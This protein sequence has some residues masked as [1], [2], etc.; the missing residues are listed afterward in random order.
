MTAFSR[1]NVAVLIEIRS[2]SS[3][4]IDPRTATIAA[5]QQYQALPP[6]NILV[7][8]NGT[9]VPLL[10]VWIGI[11]LAIAVGLAAFV[12]S[13]GS[14]QEALNEIR[15][16]LRR[17]G[18]ALGV[19]ALGVVGAMAFSMLDFSVLHG[20]GEWYE[21]GFNDFWRSWSSSAHMTYAGGYGHIYNLDNALET[22]PGWL[23][24]IAPISRLAFGLSF[25]YPSAVLYPS[26]FWVAGPLFLCA[27]ALPMCAGD[28][29]MQYLGVKDVRRR[30]LV[31][32]T[33]AITLPPI[34]LFGHSE[35]LLA[36][37]AMLYGLIAAL[38]GRGRATGWWLG[39]ALAFQFFAFLAVPI[40]LVLLKRRQWVGALVPMVAVPLSL[41]IV[42]LAAAPMSTLRQLIHQ[43]VFYDLGYISPTWS[44]D[45]GVGA[46]IRAL[47][48]LS[49]IPAA[50]VLA[51]I[52]PKHSGARAE[53][54][55][56]TLALLF[57]L[58]VCEPEL[59]P[60]FL[61][62]SLALFPLCASK[63]RWSRLV[64]ASVLA[65]WLNWW[66]HD[67]VDA[68]WLLW[69]FLV[70]Q[71]AALSWLAFPRVAVA[72]AAPKRPLSGQ[73]SS[74]TARPGPRNA[75]TRKVPSP[76]RTT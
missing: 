26:A 29:W 73:R 47:V 2:K 25:P 4:G 17:R 20:V 44:L 23:I 9:D 27:M 6:G 30:L 35:D 1:G 65:V 5:Q 48:A 41:L 31:L 43:Q 10:V 45:P 14:A 64:A 49:A 76:S 57:T 33:M 52:L 18:L 38:E 75:A 28:R 40:A 58:R 32:G 53:I 62:P 39:V 67:A 66:L 59:V 74:G 37:G 21:A 63:A 8:T 7:S 51:R 42:P 69:F 54:V 19:A 16:R 71:L 70:A 12:R 68:R 55:L 3:E 11:L 36:L 15:R 34:A 13:R 61:A 24:L 22:A 72:D 50:I 60:Y 46:F 56:W